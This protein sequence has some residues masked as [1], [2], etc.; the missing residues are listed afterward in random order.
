MGV[1]RQERRGPGVGVRGCGYCCWWPSQRYSCGRSGAESAM[2]TIALP[3]SLIL[4]AM[5][6]ACDRD[7]PATSAAPPTPIAS[8]PTFTERLTTQQKAAC[9]DFGTL[10]GQMAVR[11]DDGATLS[12]ELA[13]IRRLPTQAA[14]DEF[15]NMA[16]LV[17]DN[18]AFNRQCATSE[19]MSVGMDCEMRIAKTQAGAKYFDTAEEI[20]VALAEFK[21]FNGV[22]LANSSANTASQS[23]TSRPFQLSFSQRCPLK[24]VKW[25]IQ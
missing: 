17:Y 12:Q 2:A 4:Y 7:A 9:A 24:R 3:I 1:K 6:T 18:P 16:K 14:V 15:T 25:F 19:A 21:T 5:L 20:A 8:L 10:A 23:I 22:P 13:T 11:R